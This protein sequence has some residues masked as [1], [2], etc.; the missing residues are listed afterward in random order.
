MSKAQGKC[1][2]SHS[3]THTSDD[4]PD[5][6]FGKLPP[7]WLSSKRRELPRAKSIRTARPKLKDAT[8]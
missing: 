2:P 1:A 6:K 4:S 3:A 5:T 7:I 8:C